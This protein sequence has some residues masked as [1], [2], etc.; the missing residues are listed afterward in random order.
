MLQN[1]RA[2]SHSADVSFQKSVSPSEKKSSFFGSKHTDEIESMDAVE[3]H[4]YWN[5][6]RVF[7][8]GFLC[9]LLWF[10]GS[11]SRYRNSVNKRW[12]KRC[13]LAALYFSVVVS[14]VALVVVVKM[15][16]H[17]ASRQS[18]SDQIRA[19]IAD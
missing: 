17:A 10:Y 18:Q 7:W 5:E 3:K 4:R 12:Q 11:V 1:I 6:K 16:G 13:R 8:F 15:A 2:P 14:V 19:V 9:P